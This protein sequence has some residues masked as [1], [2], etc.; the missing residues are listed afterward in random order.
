VG[1]PQGEVAF[2]TGTNEAETSLVELRVMVWMMT[3]ML[4]EFDGPI[5]EPSVD[6]V[7]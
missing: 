4:V 1:R 3:A 6:E 7:E 2:V 5:G